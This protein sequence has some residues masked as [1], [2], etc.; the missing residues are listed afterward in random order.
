MTT[1][2]GFVLLRLSPLIEIQNL[3]KLNFST[4][5]LLKIILKAVTAPLR[6]CLHQ[7]ANYLV[8]AS[9][10]IIPSFRQEF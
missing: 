2:E 7:Q 10:K 5:S 3:N 4:L 9:R 6:H 1:R 8:S